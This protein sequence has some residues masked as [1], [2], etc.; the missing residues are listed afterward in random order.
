[1]VPTWTTSGDSLRTGTSAI[2]AVITPGVPDAPETSPEVVAVIRGS[3]TVAST[4]MAMVASAS[5]VA[6][7]APL[8]VPAPSDFAGGDDGP[9]AGTARRSAVIT[10]RSWSIRPLSSPT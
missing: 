7:G 3:I 5:C 10:A 9:G 1:P 8:V 2:M 6:A 4:S